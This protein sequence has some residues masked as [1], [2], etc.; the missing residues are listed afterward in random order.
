M[1]FQTLK[2]VSNNNFSGHQDSSFAFNIPE[3][4]SYQSFEGNLEYPD[5][6][7]QKF[8]F[9][10]KEEQVSAFIA[11]ILR[12]VLRKNKLDKFK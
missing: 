2:K 6:S 1:C 9:N 11:K 4:T 8:N 5:D 10:P 7:K 12:A 3:Q